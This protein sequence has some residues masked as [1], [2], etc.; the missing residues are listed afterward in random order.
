MTV[1]HVTTM[2]V[3]YRK[4]CDMPNKKAWAVKKAL[5]SKVESLII[6]IGKNKK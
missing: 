5:Q 4:I 1:I 2:T 3:S 6:M